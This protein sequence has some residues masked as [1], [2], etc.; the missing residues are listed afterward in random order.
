MKLNISCVSKASMC[1]GCGACVS[2][3]STKSISLK[4]SSLGRVYAIVDSNCTHCGLCV[5]VCPSYKSD[6]DFDTFFGLEKQKI[7]VGKAINH[8]LKSNGQSGGAVTAF[9]SYLFNEKKI[10]AALVCKPVE[11]GRGV[12]YI[13][14]NASQLIQCQKSIY[15]PVSLLTQLDLLHPFKSV[16][17]VGLPCHLSAM[18]RL[19]KIKKIPIN[20][21]LGLICDRTLCSGISDSI[22]EYLNCGKSQSISIKWRDKSVPGFSY[23]NAP[24]S[25]TMHDGD[26]RVI[27]SR[28]RQQIKKYFTPPRCL[29]CPDKLNLSSDLVF[30]DPWNIYI[31]DGQGESLIIANTPKGCELLNH[32]VNY[33]IISSKECTSEQLDK[34]QHIRQRRNQVIVYSRLFSLFSSHKHPLLFSAL[35]DKTISVVEFMRALYGVVRFKVFEL[36]PKVWV[37]KYVA[38][39]ISNLCDAA[40]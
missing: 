28:V 30:G 2:I 14:T 29:V 20:Y 33:K 18:R 19:M 8:F 12:P 7:I 34:S 35:S 27:P 37:C 3:C 25:V 40:D 15:T 17:I 9:L 39:K 13:A 4:E 10:D 1:S 24:I 26:L 31:E 16:A 21:M 38:R 11:S 22:C 32:A 36:L 6:Y 23:H 5:K